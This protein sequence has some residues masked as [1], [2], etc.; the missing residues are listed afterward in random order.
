[1][2]RLSALLSLMTIYLMATAQTVHWITADDSLVNQQNSWIEFRK[3]FAL[4]KKPKK[5]EAKIAADT[6]YWLWVNGELA[7]FE[8][9]LKRGP[10]RTDSYY[11]LV[12]L[13]PWLK[14][15]SNDVR[16]LL[17]HFGK[18]GFSHV[19]SGR[20]GVIVDAPSIGLS[21][22][23]TWQS[24]RLAAYQTCDKPYANFRLPESN[25]RYDARLLGQND[26]KPSIEIGQWGEGAWGKLIERPIPQWRDYGVK[27]VAFEQSEDN[28]GN[29]VLAASLPY[30]MQMTPVID[31]TDDNEGT[32]VRLETDHVRGGSQDCVR[33]EYITKK[34]RQQYESLGW[35]NGDVLRIIYPKNANITIHNVGYRETGYDCAFEGSFTCSD[36]TV[37]RFWQKAMRTLYVNMRD[38]YFDCPDRERAQWWGDV[39]I[40]MG[41]SFYQLSPRANALMRKAIRELVSWQKDDGTLFS[42]I[43]AENWDKELPAQ[44]LTSISTYGFWY[45]YMHT[46]DRETMDYA[47]PAMKKYLALW[48]LDEDGMTQYRRGGWPWGDWGTDVDMRLLLA[49]WHYMALQSAVNVAQ[50]IGHDADICDYERQ[51][52]SIRKA[53]NRCWNGYAYRHPS[54]QGATD[55]RVQALAIVSGLADSTKYE[56]I[57]NV[58]K[59]QEFASPYME[60]YVYEAL[61]RTGHGDYALERFKRRFGPMIADTLHTTLYEGWKEGGY[62]GGSTNHA[63]SGGMLTDICEQVI[64]LRPT[65]PGWQTFEVAPRLIIPEASITVPTVRGKIGVSYSDGDGFTMTITVPAGTTARITLPRSDYKAILLNGKPVSIDKLSVLR[66]GTYVV[67]TVAGHSNL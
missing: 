11:D 57:F 52:Q 13:A 10:N 30:N 46:G 62:G 61:M 40:L 37:N 67:R 15:G 31:L 65:S 6:K 60:K 16:L 59:T 51:M 42:P 41:Q 19:N 63:W 27:S 5:A 1:M 18:P 29:V 7:V 9:G 3:D 33:A 34:G 45:Y 38:N 64:G 50:L 23:R 28:R 47:Y 43:P 32:T 44:M 24:Q 35:M 12:D 54:Y 4:K 2:K 22:D 53:F 55:D 21:T 8:G 20:A 14:K 49:A 48:T 66:K 17:W 39:T 26:Q 25:I 36:S 58:I 56:P